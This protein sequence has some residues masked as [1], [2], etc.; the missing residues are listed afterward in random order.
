MPCCTFDKRPDAFHP[1]GIFFVCGVLLLVVRLIRMDRRDI[2]HRQSVILLDCIVFP[3]TELALLDATHVAV[4]PWYLTALIPILAVTIGLF[5]HTILEAISKVTLRSLKG[6][7]VLVLSASMFLNAHQFARRHHIGGEAELNI[8]SLNLAMG[9]TIASDGIDAFHTMGGNELCIQSVR[10]P[11]F[12]GPERHTCL[13]NLE[14]LIRLRDPDIKTSD[15]CSALTPQAR[16]LALWLMEKA[17]FE[18]L[19]DLGPFIN[20]YEAPRQRRATDAETPEEI[21]G[22]LHFPSFSRYA[23]WTDEMSAHLFRLRFDAE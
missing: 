19:P 2:Q 21:L 4:Y 5:L 16:V 10:S 22:L 14:C 11:Y 13:K 3:V 1:V 15:K 6:P 17:D 23:S 18:A 8:S 7:L 9:E 12:Y 20:T